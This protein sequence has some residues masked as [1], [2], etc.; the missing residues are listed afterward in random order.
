MKRE[1][2]L[3]VGPQGSGKTTLANKMMKDLSV[4]SISEMTAGLIMDNYI[5]YLKKR[6]IGKSCFYVHGFHS[7]HQLSIY[8]S[9]L[10]KETPLVIFE[11]QGKLVDIPSVTQN[12]FN[13]IIE[14]EN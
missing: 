5:A 12:L 2:T 14:F 8:S 9:E 7:V 13:T 1:R 4:E 3:I 11:Y 6:L 10:L